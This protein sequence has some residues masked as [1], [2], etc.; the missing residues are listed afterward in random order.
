MI[1]NIA[2]IGTGGVGGYFGAKLCRMSEETGG[3][4]VSFIARG[5]HLRAIQKKGLRVK[6]AHEGEFI[7]HPDL[8]TDQIGS[9]PKPDLCLIC[10]KGFDLEKV[11]RELKPLVKEK[12][13]ILPLL[14]GVDIHRRIR[15]FISAGIVLPACVYVGTHIES[16]AVISQNGGACEIL[17]GEDPGRYPWHREELFQIFHKSGIRHSWFDD[18]HPEIWKKFLFIASF[19][20]ICAC[21]NRTIGEVLAFEDLT[22]AVRSV[23]EEILKLAELSGISL[24]DGILEDALGKGR[25]F[26]YETKTS[27]QRDFEQ[28]DRADERDLFGDTIIRLCEE[29]SVACPVTTQIC[30]RLEEIKPR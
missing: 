1:K 25:G 22:G 2:V 21:Y 17:F 13:L 24:K 7:C 12:T 6:T 14:N 20:L 28:R 9:I 27:F 10:V 15:S 18:P 8:A 5:E 30:R 26:P 16:P 3:F 29:A 11:L 4:H 19:G 23:M